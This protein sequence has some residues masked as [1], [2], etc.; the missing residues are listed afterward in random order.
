MVCE[1]L[2]SIVEDLT[3]GELGPADLA[4]GQCAARLNVPHH[5]LLEQ[6]AVIIEQG[7]AA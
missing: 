1:K 3:T 2:R 6:I 4:A 5:L 7:A